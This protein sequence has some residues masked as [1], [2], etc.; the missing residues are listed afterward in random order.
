MYSLRLLYERAGE[1]IVAGDM[2]HCACVRYR[3]KVYEYTINDTIPFK[4]GV[5]HLTAAEEALQLLSMDKNLVL[6]LED[7]ERFSFEFSNV[8]LGRITIRFKRTHAS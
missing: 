7:G 3:L 8:T 5:A 4:S 1:G 6:Q 2:I